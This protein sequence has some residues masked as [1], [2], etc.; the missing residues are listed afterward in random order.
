MAPRAWI[1]LAATALAATLLGATLFFGG[2]R[3]ELGPDGGPVDPSDANL[4]EDD[5][6]NRQP[7]DRIGA[8]DR[9]VWTSEEGT[10][11]DAQR[12]FVTWARAEPEPDGRSSVTD[13]EATVFF[14][15]E[16]ALKITA[17]RGHFVAPDNKLRNGLFEGNVTV[18]YIEL[19]EAIRLDDPGAALDLATDRDVVIRC[20]LDGPT[21]FS[22]EFG[23][24]RCSDGE[25][26]VTGPDTEFLGRGLVLRFNSRRERI[27]E[28]TITQGREL[29]FRAEAFADAEADAVANQDEVDSGA[30]SAPA[31]DPTT[32]RTSP[33]AQSVTARG[34]R[35]ANANA[36]A[37]ET[38][39][40]DG[41]PDQYYTCLFD[42]GVVVKQTA[43]GSRM[44]GQQLALTF[45]LKT[46]GDAPTLSDADTQS[47]VVDPQAQTD[48]AK[49]DALAARMQAAEP[50]SASQAV[51][52]GLS[53]ASNTSED[54]ASDPPRG[55]DSPTE[56]QDARP[57]LSP[58]GLP[59]SLRAGRSLYE[60]SDRDVVVTWSG[61]MVL[62]P[63]DVKPTELAGPEDTLL[64]LRGAPGAPARAE[65]G[66]ATAQGA[67]VRYLRSAGEAAV[68]SGPETQAELE[69]PEMGRITG[70][71]MRLNSARRSAV[72]LGPA[73]LVTRDNPDAGA[74]SSADDS[75]DGM[76]GDDL[77]VT[78]RDRLTLSFYPADAAEDGGEPN[79]GD[80]GGP[81]L[82]EFE[83]QVR[84]AHPDL[85]LRSEALALRFDDGPDAA[86]SVRRIDA[87][88]A[89]NAKLRSNDGLGVMTGDAR[90]T[91]MSEASEDPDQ[92]PQEIGI[93]GRSLRID[94]LPDGAGGVGPRRVEA[95]GRVT[96]TQG[97]DSLQAEEVE[98]QL[99]PRPAEPVPE[100]EVAAASADA[101][102][103]AIATRPAE[104][105]FARGGEATAEGSTIP[106]ESEATEPEPESPEYAVVGFAARRNVVVRQ[107][108][109]PT[110]VRSELLIA[111]P[112]QG[113]LTLQGR[114]DAPAML[115]R[116]RS[117]LEG[118]F[119]VLDDNAQSAEVQGPGAFTS[120]A[121]GEGPDSRIR[122]R[123]TRSM[124]LD[125]VAGR[126]LFLGS[127]DAS[128]VSL[129][130]QTL[131]T[132]EE[133]DVRFD[134]DALGSS[135][136]DALFAVD[137]PADTD[138]QVP[139]DSPG[140][141]AVRQAT[142]R[143]DAVFRSRSVDPAR[144]GALL[145]RLQLESQTLVFE[146]RPD[147]PQRQGVFVPEAG[148]MLVE[149]YR[150]DE[151]EPA[152]PEPNQAQAEPDGPDADAAPAQAEAQ[153]EPEDRAPR[154][155][156][157]GAGAV[158]EPLE[159]E[160][161]GQA[162]P[163]AA[164]EPDAPALVDAP[165]NEA[166]NPAGLGDASGRGQTLFVWDERMTLDAWANDAVF[167]GAVRV[168]HRPAPSADPSA[169]PPR[170]AR[171]L[172]Q[173]LTADLSATGGL[174][175]WVEGEAAAAEIQSIEAQGEV[176]LEYETRSAT[177]DFL[178]YVHATRM[179]E[180][181]ARPQR[182]VRVREA[183]RPTDLLAQRVVWD[184]ERNE[185][186][187]TDVEGSVAPIGR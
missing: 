108:D 70:R 8:I 54:A 121:E 114:A 98:L 85:D 82:A 93:A 170:P 32:A 164:P 130:E 127:I 186:E 102:S 51:G 129:E 87:T 147:D 111:E 22:L 37:A 146:N 73:R 4:T 167:V 31:T 133:L 103:E 118:E 174:G 157:V 120:R 105:S 109:P 166:A 131:I 162:E 34:P 160:Q 185:I 67:E 182:Q 1:I 180:L 41:Q 161:A 83:G 43:E 184:L 116:D 23:E 69:S 117:V 143:G 71:E 104:G 100:S 155:D 47:P 5:L 24:V 14:G 12:T 7:T 94:L 92:A 183:G 176:A 125:G 96:L 68:L 59:E 6:L 18:T 2:E 106:A 30:K 58:R 76:S 84:V 89:V 55:A 95:L 39:T 142:A 62:R 144:G 63:H 165:A 139:A 163:Q 28:L 178:E 13:P 29:R 119:I 21:T 115:R 48:D 9:G 86:A 42:S 77:N 38:H 151:A 17:D 154:R 46:S 141:L 168:V 26:Q 153:V 72:V 78:W 19:S 88:G 177:A 132:A 99:E 74:A 16:R 110:E 101:P 79:P 112:E 187:A 156:R 136:G 45:S 126:A 57:G 123:W 81:R 171:L 53:L 169:E 181:W 25:V 10:G 175:A 152:E 66:D 172:A 3:V 158:F 50:G 56:R 35:P 20:F 97:Q 122:I 128:T 137:A 49:L 27:E 60:R 150:T 11:P 36:E 113:R 61:Q 145:T 90:P 91:G 52:Y 44:T 134:P 140:A 80:L 124:S 65:L 149:D 75:G 148:R 138:G 15:R 33:Q 135:E 40:D 173:R 159:G 107:A 179:A 64:V